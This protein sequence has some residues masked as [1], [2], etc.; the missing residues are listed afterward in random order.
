MRRREF[1]TLASGAAIAWP[2]AARAQIEVDPA[3]AAPRGKSE[4]LKTT[5][6]ENGNSVRL[7]AM[8]F[9]PS[10]G[11]PFPLAVFNHGSTGR[12]PTP[13]SVKRT[14]FS[15]EVADFLNQRGWLVA[16]PQRRGRGKSDGPCDEELLRNGKAKFVCDKDTAQTDSARALNDIDAAIRVLLERPDVAPGPILIG[17]H[18]RGGILSVAYAGMHSAQTLGVLNFVGGWI[19]EGCRVAEPINQELSLRGARFDRPTIWLYGQGDPFYSIA[20]SR[21]N[22]VAFENAGGKGKF[23][24]FDTPTNVGHDVIRHPDLWTEPVKAYLD[25][26]P[27]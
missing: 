10:G 7:E 26:L 14:W 9:K 5:L 25:A 17:G 6:N 4:F 19:N 2:L 24:E 22:F 3:V 27:A 15:V 11:G 20:H 18:S 8:I 21:K 23:V 16:F 13:E 12:N 1:I